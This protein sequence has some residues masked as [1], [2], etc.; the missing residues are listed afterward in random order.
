MIADQPLPRFASGLQLRQLALQV[1]HQ[2]TQIIPALQQLF[3]RVGVVREVGR[4]LFRGFACCCT[5]A[6]GSGSTMLR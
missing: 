6:R 3:G 1:L 5:L 2:Q 4:L